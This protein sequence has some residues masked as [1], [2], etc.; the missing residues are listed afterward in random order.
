MSGIWVFQVSCTL[1]CNDSSCTHLLLEVDMV[2]YARLMHP[3]IMT[4]ALLPFPVHPPSPSPPP[5]P[6]PPPQY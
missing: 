2:D 1:S 4:A 6:P 3:T 5:P